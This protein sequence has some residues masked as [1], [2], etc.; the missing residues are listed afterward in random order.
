M[1]W[2][3]GDV[4]TAEVVSVPPDTPY[5]ECVEMLEVHRVGA[6]PVTDA[7]GRLVGI[8]TESDL[9]RKQEVK[10]GGPG[11]ARASARVASE[12]MTHAAVTVAPA[13]GIAE[14]ARLM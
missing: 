5:K 12:A 7:A 13:T 3:V 2:K 10:G 4:M 11:F 6:L 9:L 1:S 8:L 14:A